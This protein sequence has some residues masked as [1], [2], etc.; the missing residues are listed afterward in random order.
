M[1]DILQMYNKFMLWQ[2]CTR[3]VQDLEASPLHIAVGLNSIDVAKVL[4]QHDADVD[5]MDTF[6]VRIQPQLWRL[7]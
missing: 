3:L 6:L 2:T 4:L 1:H 5:A 7:N